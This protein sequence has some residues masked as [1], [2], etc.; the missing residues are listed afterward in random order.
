M[1][2]A[3]RI[4][5][6]TLA[7]LFFLVRPAPA[8]AFRL[9]DSGQR[10]CYQDVSPYAEIPCAG[11]GQDGAYIQNELNY[12]DNGHG[13]V[14]DNNTGLI[15][16][17][18]NAARVNWYMASGTYHAAWNPTSLGVCASLNLGGATDWRLPTK[19]ELMSIVD[20][21]LH[22]LLAPMIN[23]TYFADTFADFYWTSTLC[24]Y[25]PDF[26]WHVHFADGDDSEGSKLSE[27]YVR[28]VRGGQ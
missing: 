20:F 14:T 23:T 17:K 10:T 1:R 25:N 15:W 7:V 16:Q 9:P 2:R 13:T 12:T 6:A 27:L 3:W 24:A 28:C 4:P 26:A 18:G 21:A 19:K 8:A 22:P 11:T 5:P